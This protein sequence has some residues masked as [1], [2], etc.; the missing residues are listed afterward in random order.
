[1]AFI[2]TSFSLLLA[3]EFGREGWKKGSV[4]IRLYIIII[5]AAFLAPIWIQKQ[6]EQGIDTGPALLELYLSGVSVP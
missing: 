3:T 6:Q 4:H 1:M 2:E 5:E